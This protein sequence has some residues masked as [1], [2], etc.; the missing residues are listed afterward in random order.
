MRIILSFIF[1]NNHYYLN[2]RN[3]HSMFHQAVATGYLPILQE[4]ILLL[5]AEL[6]S[7]TKIVFIPYSRAFRVEIVAVKNDFR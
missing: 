6:C 1:Y 5:L 7:V 2:M 4:F 3:L